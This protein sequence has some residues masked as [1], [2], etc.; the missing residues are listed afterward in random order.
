MPRP[1]RK[2]VDP[3]ENVPAYLEKSQLL[4][5]L[6]TAKEKGIIDKVIG[7]DCDLNYIL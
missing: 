4:D 2:I 7:V 1:K 3:D 6:E 5:F